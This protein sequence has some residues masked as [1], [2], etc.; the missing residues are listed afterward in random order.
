[1][2]K[3]LTLL[4]TVLFASTVLAS[5]DAGPDAQPPPP[6]PVDHCNIVGAGEINVTPGL[7]GFCDTFNQVER[8]GRNGDILDSKWTGF[9]IN[10]ATNPGIGQVNNFAPAN[11]LQLCMDD[12]PSPAFDI[13][14]NGNPYFGVPPHDFYVCGSSSADGTSHAYMP[15]GSSGMEPNHWMDAMDDNDQY[16]AQ[17]IRGLQPFDFAG[18]TG[19]ITFNVDAKTEGA[20]SAWPE[21]WL[22]PDPIQLPHDDFPGSHEFPREGVGFQFAADWCGNNGKFNVGARNVSSAAGIRF[23]EE[24]HNYTETD[25]SALFSPCYTTESDMANHIEIKISQTHAAVYGSNDDGSNFR[26]LYQTDFDTPLNFTRGYVSFEH[27]QYAANKFNDM[28]QT[29][30]HWHA[31]GWD[32]PVIP[33]NRSSQLDDANVARPDGTFNLGYQTPTATFNMPFVYSQPAASQA[34]IVY[35]VYWYSSPETLHTILN[36]HDYTTTD[37]DPNTPGHAYQWH[38]IVQPVNVAD[39]QDYNQVQITNT[40]CTDNCPTVA[41]VDLELVP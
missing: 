30:Y 14:R 36:G 2:K 17:G 18:R 1:M 26:L 34:Y 41:N 40:G 22:T 20:H 29:T 15:D 35:S 4:I 24:F 9:R 38:Y 39:V 7:T 31:L 5:C 27:S 33:A 25:H 28:Q 13:D 3:F 37:P 10:Q 16:V 6:P 23:V 32:G 12:L 21:V 11:N 8:G 19:T